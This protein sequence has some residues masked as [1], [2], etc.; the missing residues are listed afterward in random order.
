MHSQFAILF[1]TLVSS[2]LHGS[3][4]DGDGVLILDESLDAP[5]GLADE[6]EEGGAV[7]LP[8]LWQLGGGGKLAAGELEGDFHAA[9]PDV[10]VVLHAAR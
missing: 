2:Y 1:S 3:A 4:L 10:V 9:V 7:V 6:L 5:V 8:E